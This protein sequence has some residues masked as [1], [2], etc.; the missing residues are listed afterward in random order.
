MSL[1]HSGDTFREALQ[2]LRGGSFSQLEPLFDAAPGSPGTTPR[3]VEW[4][5]QGRFRDEPEA[6][7]EAL[8]CAC[9]L[10]KV[11]VVE[12]LLAQGVNPSGGASTGLDAFHWAANR[13]QLDTVR[14]LIRVKA[15][16]ETRNMHGD[17]VLGTAI[18]SALNE[19]RPDH[20]TIIEELVKAGAHVED[21]EQPAA[22]LKGRLRRLRFKRRLQRI[23]AILRLNALR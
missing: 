5:E 1:A 21:V 22:Y 14:V 2:R 13:G 11:S 3:I 6:L 15:P 9:F 16:L 10:G 18:W 7:A 8:T 12:H 4:C 23:D 17:T 20:L 19:A